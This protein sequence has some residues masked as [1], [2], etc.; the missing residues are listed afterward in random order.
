MSRSA[1]RLFI[2]C[3]S[4]DEPHAASLLKHLHSA[5]S[6]GQ[7]VPC[8]STVLLG[9]KIAEERRHQLAA[10]DL[11]VVLVS[12]D[13]LFQHADEL[14]KILEAQQRSLKV[15]LV[16][17][18]HTLL[19]GTLLEGI[20]MVPAD[21]PVLAWRLQDEPWVEVA[22]VILRLLALP[23]RAAASEEAAQAIGAPSPITVLLVAADP[24]D[25][26]RLGLGREVKE[27]SRRLQAARIA[28]RFQLIEEWAVRTEELSRLLLLHR[29]KVVHFCGSGTST[30]EILLEN[31]QGLSHAVPQAALGRLFQVLN[32]QDGY[33]TPQDRICCVVLNSCYAEEQARVIAEH[34]D[35]ALGIRGLVDEKVALAFTAGFY[36]GLS[37]GQSIAKA[38]ALGVVQVELLGHSSLDRFHLIS[39]PGVDLQQIRIF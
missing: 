34:V 13:L 25:S 30:G 24:S 21:K 28:N 7:L 15:V 33:F 17:L 35:C 6:S 14:Q 12:P 36:S 2:S 29:P 11:V 5:I 18:R 3:A 8:Y 27:L 16:L 32:K 9:A 39:R 10:A 4:V 26:A 22:K 20:R 19:E 1:T 37:D 38:Y 31:H 23:R